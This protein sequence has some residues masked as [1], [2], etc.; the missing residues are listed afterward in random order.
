MRSAPFVNGLKIVA[1]EEDDA[2]RKQTGNEVVFDVARILHFVDGD[3]GEAVLPAPAYV[4]L[5]QQERGADDEV[6]K[7]QGMIG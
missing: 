7:I 2:S 4:V 6:F 3:V 1:A 5:P